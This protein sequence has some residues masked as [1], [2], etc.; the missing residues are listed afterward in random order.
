MARMGGPAVPSRAAAWT[1]YALAGLTTVLWVFCALPSGVPVGGTLMDDGGTPLFR[2]PW[3]LVPVLVLLVVAPAA[4]A[5]TSFRMGRLRI[6]AATDACLSLYAALV[7]TARPGMLSSLRLDLGAPLALLIALYALGALSILET[8]RLLRGDVR[9][10]AFHLGGL[11]LAL[12]LLVLALPAGALIEAGQD[13]ALLLLPF[14]LV[15]VSAG[16]ARLAKS[17]EG[18]GLTAAL[19]HLVLAGNLLIT[20]RYTI[21]RAAPHLFDLRL[22]GR[23]T[24]D[25]AWTVLALAGLQVIVQSVLCLRRR[26]RAAESAA[27]LEAPA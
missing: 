5:L 1:G 23:V 3:A 18:L 7:L 19:V 20:L 24:L 11:R 17:A 22:P 27:V 15:A 6:L 16:G 4:M 25:L 13:L 9:P 26:A 2:E 8:R 12:C 21:L 10:P 14:L